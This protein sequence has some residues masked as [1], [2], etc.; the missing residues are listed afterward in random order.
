MQSGWDLP[1]TFDFG[2]HQVGYG[3][4]SNGDPLVLLHGTPFSSVVWRR[5]A[6]QLALHRRVYYFD[7]FGYGSRRRR[8]RSRW[9]WEN[10]LFDALLEHWASTGRTWWRTTSAGPP[11]YA[12][13]C[14]TAATTAR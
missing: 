2:G 4:L 1:D 13:T 8:T 14:S 12:P 6:P 11:R 10:Q 7:L 9:V 5:I 3:T